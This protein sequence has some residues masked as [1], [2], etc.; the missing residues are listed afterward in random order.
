MV[1]S[2]S[3]KHTR[4]EA[5]SQ[6]SVTAPNECIETLIRARQDSASRSPASL[7]TSI[8]APLSRDMAFTFSPPLPM[9][10]PRSTAGPPPLCHGSKQLRDAA[11]WPTKDP[12]TCI[13]FRISGPDLFSLS[14]IFFTAWI[15][16]P[17]ASEDPV[18]VTARSC[19]H[20]DKTSDTSKHSLSLSLLA[21]RKTQTLHQASELPESSLATSMRAPVSLHNVFMVS[22]PRP[23]STPVLARIHPKNGSTF[24]S[25]GL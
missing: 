14:T 21:P 13:T 23:I 7:E 18:I 1:T 2:R 6:T 4:S 5:A 15:A 12:D 9:I 25:K 10:I 8:L 3:F 11:K 22:P 24:T 19:R 16:R 17:T 20:F